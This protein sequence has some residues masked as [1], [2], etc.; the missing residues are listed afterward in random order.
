M[1]D[2]HSSASER[3][4]SFSVLR[5]AL[6][7]IGMHYFL[8]PAEWG[9]SAQNVQLVRLLGGGLL[10]ASVC[11][12]VRLNKSSQALWAF[13]LFLAVLFVWINFPKN[14][15]GLFFLS[16]F[17]GL[18]FLLIAAQLNYG[19]R[20]GFG[21]ILTGLLLLWVGSLLAQ[22]VL[23]F[24]AGSVV[25]L[26]QLLHP[27]SEARIGG[28]GLLFRFTG[29]HIEPGTYANWVYLLVLLRAVVSGRLFD[30]IAVAAVTSILLTVSVWGAV[31]VSLYFIGFLLA[32]IAAGRSA[33]RTKLGVVAVLVLVMAFFFFQKFGLAIEEALNYFF[34]RAELGDASGTAKIDAYAGFLNVLG[35]AVVL[36]FPLDFDFCSGCASPQDSGIFVNLVVRAGLLVTIFIFSVLLLMFWRMFGFPVVLV[37]MPVFTSKVFYFDPIFWMLAGLG[38]L[39]ARKNLRH[40]PQEAWRLS[41]SR[42]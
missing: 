16:A 10:V 40:Y 29:V 38:V 24:G 15:G 22:V 2:V 28:A 30:W 31:A 39:Y 17:V 18:S 1:S 8:T 14:P 12:G 20:E 41:D 5:V 6:A 35:D 34:V 19:V 36:G 25:D 26:H 11:F 13:Y 9:V 33:D 32:L 7:V 37:V 42:V 23:Y 4:V 3:R 27:Y 21:R